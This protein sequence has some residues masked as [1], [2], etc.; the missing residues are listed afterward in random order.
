MQGL[1]ARLYDPAMGLVAEADLTAS[2]YDPNGG[3]WV[4]ATWNIPGLPQ[5]L[6][7]AVFTAGAGRK[8]EIA[9]LMVLN[10]GSH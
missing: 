2:D 8:P 9:K 6:F 4:S 3:G 7:F 5:G 1:V 10:R